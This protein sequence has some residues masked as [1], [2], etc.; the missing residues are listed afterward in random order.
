MSGELFYFFL[1]GR[2]T[3][4]TAYQKHLAQIAVGKARILH[5]I[6][7]RDC[8]LFNQIMGQFIEFGSGKVHIKVF[9]SL[10][11]SGNERKV[12]IGGGR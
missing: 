11:R 2:N 9:G 7:Y 1:Y 12:D 10:C 5:G 3:G 4:R 6:L 8:C